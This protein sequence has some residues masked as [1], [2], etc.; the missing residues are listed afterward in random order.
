[1]YKRNIEA[2]LQNHFWHGEAI[3]ITYSECVYVAL[4]IWYVQR[5]LPNISSSVGWLAGWLY[6]I[7]FHFNS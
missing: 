6:Y 2:R 3:Y 7:F 4:V 5:M 1:M